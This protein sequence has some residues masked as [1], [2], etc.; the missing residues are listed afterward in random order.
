MSY[1][2]DRRQLSR[3]AAEYVD[4]VLKGAKPADTR[5]LTQKQFRSVRAYGRSRVVSTRRLMLISLPAENAYSAI[6][7]PF[8]VV[9]EGSRR[10]PIGSPPSAITSPRAKQIRCSRYETQ[11]CGLHAHRPPRQQ[12]HPAA[13]SRRNGGRD[14]ADI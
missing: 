6:W 2:V 14:L 9:G 13:H 11:A 12:W 4:K 8:A 5:F 1:G 10:G 3:R 7:G